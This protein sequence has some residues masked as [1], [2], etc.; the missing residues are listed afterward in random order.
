MKFSQ[1]VSSK[2][3]AKYKKTIIRI[4]VWYIIAIFS[5]KKQRR[6]SF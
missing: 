6:Q 2:L 5:S 3:H 4:N 1:S